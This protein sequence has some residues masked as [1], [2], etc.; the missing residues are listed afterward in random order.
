MFKTLS[1]IFNLRSVLLVT[2]TEVNRRK[3]SIY[4]RS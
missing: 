1:T 4:L 3:P 2:E